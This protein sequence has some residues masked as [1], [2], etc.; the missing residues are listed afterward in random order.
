VVY[1]SI[2]NPGDGRKNWEDLL[3]GFL[4]ALGECADATL[5]LKLITR[6]PV[7]LE[8]VAGYYRKL[9]RR[10]RCRVVFLTDYLSDEQMHALVRGSAYYITTTRAEGNCLPVMNYLAAGRPVISTCTTAVSDYFDADLGFVLESHPEP[11]IWPHDSSLR[12]KTSWGRLVWPSLVE[13]LRR[14]YHVARNDRPAYETMAARAQEKMRRWAHPE[15]VWL[16]LRAALDAV[17]ALP[18]PAKQ[19]A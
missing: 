15:A 19:A 10:H 6:N 17:A 2:F 18:A 1:T 16:R 11:A 5:V 7:A 4:A 13:Q 8:R 3:S 14:S 12:F 9:D